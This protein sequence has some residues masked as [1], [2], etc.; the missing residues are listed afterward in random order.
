MKALS[1]IKFPQ[2]NGLRRSDSERQHDD[3]NQSR[4]NQNFKTIADAIHELEIREPV[5]QGGGGSGAEVSLPVASQTV[6]GGVMVGQ[7][8]S[9]SQNGVLSVTTTSEVAEDNTKPITSAA[10][11][12]TI[13]NINA[14]LSKI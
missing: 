12:A 6:L 10:V 14:L 11:Y 7:N 4:L 3:I 2:M 8:L 13:G 5:V 9:V 1:N